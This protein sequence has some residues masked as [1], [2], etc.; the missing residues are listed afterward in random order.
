MK[1]SHLIYIWHMVY[2]W[3]PPPTTQ[4]VP[5][6]LGLF[7]QAE[8]LNLI[9]EITLGKLSTNQVEKRIN[10]EVNGIR[11]IILWKLIWGCLYA[12]PVCQSW[13]SVVFDIIPY[14]AEIF[15]C[16]DEERFNSLRKNHFEL[17]Q[18]NSCFSLHCCT[19]FIP[20]SANCF[21]CKQLSM[22]FLHIM[23]Y[24]N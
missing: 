12:V 1:K 6:W 21:N 11:T 4:Y 5:E 24:W 7:C 22:N 2:P 20:G 19:L 15:V 9:W 13:N 8:A 16:I 3:F 17:F 23:Q 14:K 18:R 10:S